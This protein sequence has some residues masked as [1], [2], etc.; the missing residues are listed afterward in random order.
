MLQARPVTSVS[1]RV[2]VYGGAL[3]FV[4]SLI[5]FAVLYF[6]S[7]RFG[8]PAGPWSVADGWR[9]ALIDIVLFTA[10]ALHHSLFARGPLKRAM[11]RLFSEPLERSV[12]VWIASVLFA[13]LCLVWQPVPGAP[14][15]STGIVSAG[16]VALQLAGIVLSAVGAS[17]IGGLS[18]AG[19]PQ[20]LGA[21]S[22]TTP[23]LTQT[24]LYRLVRHPIYFGWL[25]IV[26][27]T[28]VMTGTRLVFAAISTA[29]LMAAI[30]FEERDLH[31]TFGTSYAA[32]SR[33]VRWRMIPWVY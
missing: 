22:E 31:R 24:G 19:I 14:W 10:F 13:V 15:S 27:P 11:S 9:P 29:Y 18:L 3:A 26:W 20:A 1:A 12:Y 33:R 30:P 8:E 17:R 7:P 28:P 25:L 32:Y 4:A 6:A 2:V 5:L 21:A 23:Q 16:L